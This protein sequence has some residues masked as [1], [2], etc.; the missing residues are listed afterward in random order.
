MEQSKLK[1][2]L[3]PKVEEEEE[4][5]FVFTFIKGKVSKSYLARKYEWKKK[6]GKVFSKA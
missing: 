3:L 5:K 1:V 6:S 4:K 2:K